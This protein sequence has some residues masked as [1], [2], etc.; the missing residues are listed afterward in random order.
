VYEKYIKGDIF[1]T[2]VSALNSEID[3]LDENE[4]H[5]VVVQGEDDRKIL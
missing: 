1:T 5:L 4:R 3:I 2:E